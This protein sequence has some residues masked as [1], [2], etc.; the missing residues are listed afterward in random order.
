MKNFMIIG[1]SY[2][3]YRGCIPE[4][5]AVY[6]SAE[7]AGDDHPAS[8]MAKEET[9]WMRLVEK[10][11]ANLVLNSSWSGSTI[12]YTSYNGND[13][14]MSASYIY[15][16]RQL[17]RRDFFRQNDID[18]VFVFGGTNDSW[19]EA[20]LGEVKYDGFTERDFYNVLPSIC[21]LMKV[22]KEDL[23]NTRI[24]FILNCG[25]KGAIGDCMKAA[26]ERYGIEVISLSGVE[27]LGGHP[28]ARGMEQICEQ[29]LAAL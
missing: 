3:T 9:W 24:V 5:Y 4:G 15:R 21:Y 20:P 12:G 17:W 14:S 10:T 7:G 23:P 8:K 22:M 18:T 19:C 16:Y 28:N 1:D 27:K 26:G 25:L 29:V 13:V 2:S 6:Y 11:G